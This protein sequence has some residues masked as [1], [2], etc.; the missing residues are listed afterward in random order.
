MMGK[1]VGEDAS[2]DAERLAAA[3]RVLAD[4]TRLRILGR[5]AEGTMTGADLGRALGLTAPTISHHMARLVEAGFVSVT[6]AGA[7]RRYALDQRALSSATAGAIGA[8]DAAG[9]VDP[10]TIAT[11]DAGQGSVGTGRGRQ[12]PAGARRVGRQ[13]DEEPDGEGGPP[14]DRAAA[15]TLRDFFEGERL[16]TLPAKRKKRVIVLRHILTR[17]RPGVS[18]PEQVVNDTLRPIF[19]D[20]ATLRRELVDYGFMTRENGVYRVSTTLPPR[21][22]TVA[23]EIP[24]REHAWLRALIGKAAADALAQHSDREP[25]ASEDVR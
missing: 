15:K 22:P 8:G 5:L 9:E 10:A 4:P 11:G 19:A 1:R 7:S 3:F 2:F 18:Y 6:E 12:G 14:V 24:P 23:Q 16:T 13:P 21:G 25:A 17:F 20:V